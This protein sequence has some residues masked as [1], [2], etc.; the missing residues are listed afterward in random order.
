MR[1]FD[2]IHPLYVLGRICWHNW[3]ILRVLRFTVVDRLAVFTNV[4]DEQIERSVL[5]ATIVQV[6]IVSIILP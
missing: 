5:V 4:H 6:Y 1:N 2:R 3:N